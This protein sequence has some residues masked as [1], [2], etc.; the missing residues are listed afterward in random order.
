MT[1]SSSQDTFS[2]STRPPARFRGRA[3]TQHSQHL[4]G[5]ITVALLAAAVTGGLL[6]PI[7]ALA[8]FAVGAG[9]GY[10]LSGSV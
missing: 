7:A 6:A 5:A 1:P 9:A 3:A 2:T 10:S 4:A 8:F